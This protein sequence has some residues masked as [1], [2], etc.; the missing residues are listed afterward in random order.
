[1]STLKADSFANTSGVPY[2]PAAC[3]VTL[4]GTGT[5]SITGS[6]GISSI[7]DNSTGEYYVDYSN[8]FANTNYHMTATARDN[9]SVGGSRPK[10]F[11]M[12]GY[13][14]STFTTSREMIA[15]GQSNTAE[16]I[17]STKVT[18]VWLKDF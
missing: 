18:G 5:I 6:D 16:E 11:A 7:T 14:D 13:T 10:V 3:M 17:D 8:S 9:S 2:Y 12:R 1:M 4:N 15:L